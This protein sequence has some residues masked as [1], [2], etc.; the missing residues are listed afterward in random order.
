MGVTERGVRHLRRGRG[1]QVGG[2]SLGPEVEQALPRAR[3]RWDREVGGRELDRRRQLDRDLA[4]GPVDRD[5]GQVGEQPGPPV[6]ARAGGHQVRTL[7]DEGRREA[8]GPEVRVGDH[9]LEERDVGRHATDAELREGAPGPRHRGGE[10]TAPADELGEHRVEV[11]RDLGAGVGGA[12]VQPDARAAGV[13]VGGDAADVGPEAVGR[14]LGGDAQLDGGAVDPKRV[15]RQPEVRQAGAGRDEHLRGDQV[16]VGDLLG[17]GVLDLD[18]GVHLD[19]HVLTGTLA[20]RRDEELDRAG[21]AVADRAGEGDRVPVQR[22]AGALVQ[23]GCG[24][25][26]DDLLVPAL[27]GAVALE[28][29]DHLAVGVGED[30]HLDVAWAEHG[31]LDEDPGV[32]EGALRLAHRGGE[33]VGQVVTCVHPPHA[34][35]AA[36]GDRLDEDREAHLVGGREQRGRVVGRVGGLQDRQA[37]PP[38]RRDGGDLVAGHLQHLGR[39]TDEG[40]ARLLARPREVGVLGQE[41]VA[42]VHGVGP[43]LARHTD[44]LRHVQVGPDR[45][46]PLTDLVGLVGL[47]AVDAVAV[48]PREDRD[49]PGAELGGGSE[50]ADGDLAAVGDQDLLEHRD[51]PGGSR[52]GAGARPGRCPRLA[53]AGRRG[54]PGSHREDRTR[55]S[56]PTT[57][58][59][60]RTSSR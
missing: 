59:A 54:P 32:A 4:V 12:A 52:H 43:A 44:D 9:G 25:D 23:V 17:D 27:D 47:D 8:P 58:R 5:V 50:G 14:V 26:L 40:D 19:E 48:L 6:G 49:G 42:G 56:R 24:G 21:V 34:A 29:V 55:V 20:L 33:R 11:R 37:R 22:L 36:T 13:A 16:D 60:R 41:A 18:A 51:P 45:G 1:A 28:E 15:L 30:L 35:A 57:R 38:R 7:V 31:T 10:V 46:A 53:A 3:R 2:E 39:G